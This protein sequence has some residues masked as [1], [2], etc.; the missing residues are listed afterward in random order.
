MDRARWVS[1]AL[2]AFAVAA[3]PVRAEEGP[4]VGVDL[5]ASEP[6]NGNYRGHLRTGIALN[7]FAGYMFTE[8]FGIQGQVHL[9]YHNA[10]LHLSRGDGNNN[11]DTTMLG[12][13]VGPR[14]DLPLGGPFEDLINLYAT[15]QGGMLSG[16][17]GRLNHSAPGVSL[18]G[19]IDVNLT[20]EVSV[21]L[22]GRWNR[23][24]MSPTPGDLGEDQ[25]PAERFPED[26]V[27]ATGGLSLKIAFPEEEPVPVPVVVAPPPQKHFVLRNV[28]FDFDHDSLR[29]DAIPIL[30]DV[31]RDLKE[32]EEI[33]IVAEG[34]A[35]SKGS[36][37]YNMGLSRRR[38]ERVK[39]YLVEHG[40]ADSRI[41]V[42]AAG[43]TKP[44]ASN[45]TPEGRAKNRR[46]E[47]RVD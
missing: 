11:Q 27:W 41:R 37:K 46:V 13:T 1:A 28:Y 39:K 14:F 22:F 38:A 18:G 5:G 35:D 43:E 26:I 3:L 10:D 9:D 32:D 12:L 21:G 45:A 30:D 40:V 16:L 42:E 15:A 29:P 36:E 2:F 25:D 47:I 7:P 34:H 8:N 33:T 20:K 17:S 44:V 31:V 24:Y 19:G 4:F 23:A 6:V